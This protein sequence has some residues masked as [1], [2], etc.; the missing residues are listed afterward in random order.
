MRDSLGLL[1]TRE[2]LSK[3]TWL[4]ILTSIKTFWAHTTYIVYWLLF[5]TF[6]YFV[7]CRLS[8]DSPELFIFQDLLFI[9]AKRLE[10]TFLRI[11]ASRV[12]RCLLPVTD[13]HVSF[14]RWERSRNHNIVPVPLVGMLCALADS[15][16][17]MFQEASDI[18]PMIYFISVVNRYLNHG[19]PFP[20]IP[21][22][23]DFLKA[24]STM[25]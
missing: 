17:K 3:N 15:R 9:R 24:I 23:S 8:I 19:Q 1:G 5:C 13:T 18:S 2:V 22:S 6:V 12:S 7:L 21:P 4:H 16:F 10:T 14:G 20:V 11:P 25:V